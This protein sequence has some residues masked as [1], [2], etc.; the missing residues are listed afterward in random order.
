M[1]AASIHFSVI[2]IGRGRS[3]P[4]AFPILWNKY[5]AC[6]HLHTC[7]PG[8][9]PLTGCDKK[10]NLNPTTTESMFVDRENFQSR[11]QGLQVYRYGPTRSRQ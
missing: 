11:C 6:S 3:W 10:K 7:D 5:H 9:K 8:R 2:F 1:V 4:S